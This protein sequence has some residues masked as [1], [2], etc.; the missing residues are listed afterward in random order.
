[1][2]RVAAWNG[3]AVIL[4]CAILLIDFTTGP[5]LQFPILFVIPVATAAWY[6][7]T[8]TAYALA[9]LLPLGRMVIAHF[10]EHISPYPY[11]AANAFV[12][13]A[14][15]EFIAHLVARTSRQTQ[16]LKEKI[17]TLV[18]ICN[19]EPR[20]EIHHANAWTPTPLPAS[21]QEMP[22]PD[23]PAMKREVI[24]EIL[25]NCIEMELWEQGKK[26]AQDVHSYDWLE[27]RE[28]AGR[29]W[30]SYA[31]HLISVGDFARAN[32]ARKRM[33]EIWPEGERYSAEI[34]TSAFSRYPVG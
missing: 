29:F 4:G 7:N 17:G 24:A 26:V 13:I 19:W 14:V 21:E 16:Q 27:Y 2:N 12:R 9:L 34:P 10:F 25:R 3:T 23:K 11:I 18:N 15:L 32:K 5:F 33:L 28:A 30:L 1:M 8:L 22:V 20:E 6:G 31:H